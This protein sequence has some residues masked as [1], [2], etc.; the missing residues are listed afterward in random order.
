MYKVLIYKS[1]DPFYFCTSPEKFIRTHLPE[2]NKYQ[3]L[4]Q[5]KLNSR[6][7]LRQN[8]NDLLLHTHEYEQMLEGNSVVLEILDVLYNKSH[9]EEK[10]RL[11]GNDQS[12][13]TNTVTLSD[14]LFVNFCIYSL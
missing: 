4:K 9:Q 2:D 11:V 6:E 10:I 12:E 7:N 5:A 13:S 14:I 1:F 3:L 8:R